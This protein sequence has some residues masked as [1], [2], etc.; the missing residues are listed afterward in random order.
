MI[1]QSKNEELKKEVMELKAKL[2]Q[3]TKEK[4]DLANKSMVEAS[5]TT[6]QPIDAIELTKSLAQVSLKY[7]DI[8]QLIKEKKLLE[9][10]N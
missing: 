8:S 3:V 2:L 7:K 4:E 1:I 6:S 5:P 9:K 10:Y